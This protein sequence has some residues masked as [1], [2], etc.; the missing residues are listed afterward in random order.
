LTASEDAQP[1]FYKSFA[2][3]PAPPKPVVQ[4]RSAKS[5]T[6]RGGKVISLRFDAKKDYL[7]IDYWLRAG[8]D[9]ALRP[10]WKLSR[11]LFAGSVTAPLKLWAERKEVQKSAQVR[12]RLIFAK[13]NVPRDLSSATLLIPLEGGLD[14]I[15]L[16]LKGVK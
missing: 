14:P 1:T 6:S 11:L 13:P 2:M 5:N 10:K 4:A 15:R 16:P 8:A 12:A 3:P 9:T 7:T